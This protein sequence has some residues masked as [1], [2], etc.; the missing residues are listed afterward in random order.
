MVGW[1]N[2]LPFFCLIYVK[3]AVVELEVAKLSVALLDDGE[4]KD[5]VN[6][7]FEF[8]LIHHLRH[9]YKSLHC[10]EHN[11]CLGFISLLGVAFNCFCFI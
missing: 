3:R 11:S 1:F 4:D 8:S 10:W 7:F 5:L 2:S 9:S 6:D